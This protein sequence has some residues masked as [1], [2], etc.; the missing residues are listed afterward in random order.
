M[1]GINIDMPQAD[2]DLMGKTLQKYSEWFKKGQ[3][4]AVKK[5]AVYIIRSLRKITKL[6]KKHREI[7][8]NPYYAR[9][10]SKRVRQINHIRDWYAKQGWEF[11]DKA[12]YFNRYAIE[13][14]TQKRK[15]YTAIPLARTAADARRDAMQRFPNSWN[16]KRR[17]LAHS[18]WGWMLGKLRPG[19]TAL[20]AE[21]QGISFA[22]EKTD[23]KEY[24]I[25][26]TNRL[27]YIR[28]TLKQG[29]VGEV[30]GKA[31]RAMIDEMEG[32]H[33]KSMRAAGMRAA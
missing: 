18:S 16:I 8:K 20:I 19:E 2:I 30:V 10:T 26:L 12:D 29:A 32:H 22:D 33:K 14:Y 6:S 11:K 1:I 25:E 21:K 15:Y 23:A 4:E 17:G 31:A 9:P 3:K 13:R 5:A 7:V 27:A 24:S 28:K